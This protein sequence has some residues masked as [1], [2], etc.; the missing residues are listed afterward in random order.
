MWDALFESRSDAL[1]A[2]VLPQP[3]LPLWVTALLLR[4]TQWEQ[5][6]MPMETAGKTFCT[7]RAAG[8]LS[9]SGHL[10]A[11]RGLLPSDSAH[12]PQPMAVPHRGHGE[13]GVSSSRACGK[14]GITSP[15]LAEGCPEEKMLVTHCLKQ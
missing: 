15:N 3:C 14:P 7:A 10:S 8:G 6:E 13:E 1:A 5:A 9:I 12:F 2:G 4:D 11:P